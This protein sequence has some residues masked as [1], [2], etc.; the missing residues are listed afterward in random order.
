MLQ[1]LYLFFLLLLI[2]PVS[3]AANE[4]LKRLQDQSA[5]DQLAV[6]VGWQR[7]LHIEP[8]TEGKTGKSLADD[9]RFFL[10]AEGKTNPV[11]ELDATLTA[12]FAEQSLGDEHARCRFPARFQWLQ[13]RL[14]IDINR[15][16]RPEC[17][18]SAQALS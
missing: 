7:L 11:A 12:L 8:G 17:A 1:H 10:S 15:L 14:N 2:T 4:Y 18:A 13:K 6:E 3:G 16:P 9:A 5:S